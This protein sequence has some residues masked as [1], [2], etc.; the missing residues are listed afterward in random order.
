MTLS[1]QIMEVGVTQALLFNGHQPSQ[2]IFELAGL[3]AIM[4]DKM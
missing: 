1:G 2:C 3:V 4:N